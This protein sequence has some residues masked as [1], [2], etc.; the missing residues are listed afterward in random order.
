MSQHVLLI[1]DVQKGFDEPYWGK[2][3]NPNAEENIKKLLTH[4]RE[5]HLP[6]IHVRHCSTEEQSPLK[7]GSPG[8]E[9]KD[10]VTPLDSEKQFDKSVNSAFIGTGLEE[11]LRASNLNDLVIVGLTTDHCISTT[12]R[13]AGNLGF[14]VTLVSDATAT[15]NRAGVDG[16]DISADDIHR[17]HLSSL[18]GEFCEVK[19]CEAVINSL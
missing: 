16:V 3:N 11:Y 15:F 18:H 6:V 7:P 9:F 19:S 13:M 12:T 1:V 14:N 4:W 5:K 2:R 10:E 8:N 17:I